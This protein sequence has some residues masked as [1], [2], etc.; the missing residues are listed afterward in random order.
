MTAEDSARQEFAS[1]A[2]S[3][4]S[5]PHSVG[6][7]GYASLF[8][9]Y[10][11]DVDYYEPS[12]TEWERDLVDL[13][14]RLLG[15]L[16]FILLVTIVGITGFSLIDPDAGLVRA[17]FMTAI[18][19][20]TVGY[21]EEIAVDTDG[22]R[23]FTVILILVGM[24]AVLYFVSTGTAFLLEG[25]LG[26]V[27]RRKK[28]ERELAGLNGHIIVCGSGP[29]AL[30]AASEL[31]TVKRDVVLVV[32]SPA[33]A[34]NAR[35]VLPDVPIVLGDP[36]DDDIRQRERGNYAYRASAQPDRQNRR[37]TPGRRTG[38]EDPEGRRE[39]CRL[40]SAYRWNEARF[41]A[42]PASCGHLSR[43]DAA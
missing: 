31:A 34:E 16:G 3:R 17:F 28:M 11:P 19:L 32:G 23:I 21:G 13:R 29:T 9:R 41:G 8:P 39:R 4:R 40:A 10:R 35:T 42:D 20:T 14:H 26:H 36:T 33:E 18:T 22:A 24:G 6:S 1:L 27:F 30:Y 5:Q 12:A 37:A 15:A 38:G 43:Q 7:P 25:Q 2:P